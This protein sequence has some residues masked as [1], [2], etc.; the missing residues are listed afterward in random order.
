MSLLDVCALQV[1][2]M[3]RE[4]MEAKLDNDKLFAEF[5]LREATCDKLVRKQQESFE[6]YMKARIEQEVAEASI[7]LQNEVLTDLTARTDREAE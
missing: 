1:E 5:A 4:A 2:K 3:K 7:A 6:Q